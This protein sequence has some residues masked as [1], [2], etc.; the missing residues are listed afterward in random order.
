MRFIFVINPISGKGKSKD[1]LI[2]AIE[3]LCKDGKDVEYYITQSAGDA[4]RYVGEYCNQHADT[5]VCFVAC[6]GDGT[7]NEVA[8]GAIGHD[9]AAVTA[10][11]CGSGND[12]VK[13]YGGAAY[14]MSLDDLLA[15]T[16]VPVDVLQVGDRYAINSCHFGF[17][18]YVSRMI[19]EYRHTKRNPYMSAVLYALVHGMRNQVKLSIDGKVFYEGDYLMCTISNGCYV[20][21][22][23]NNAPRSRNDDGLAEV[24]LF[25]TVSRFKFLTMMNSYKNGTHLDEKRFEKITHYTRAAELEIEVPKGF[26]IAL[27]GELIDQNRVTVRNLKGALRFVVPQGA[28]MKE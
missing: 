16:P 20:G 11:P 15:G 22:S 13:Y 27:D 1:A 7:L 5:D 10:Y 25:E 8:S 23:Y 4:T 18:S 21:G 9:N 24:C 12:Y 26:G 17:D 14:F 2:E 6:G 3:N 19:T 28:P